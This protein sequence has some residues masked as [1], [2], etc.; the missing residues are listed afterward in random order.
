M[1][2]YILSVLSSFVATVASKPCNTKPTATID[3]GPIVGV[4]TE[5]PKGHSRVNKFLGIPFSGKQERFALPKS[6]PKWIKPLQADEF[7]ASCPQYYVVN[8]AHHP[9]I[10]SGSD[11]SLSRSCPR[12][13]DLGKLI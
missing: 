11:D 3:S 13:F 2:L 9:S 4:A 8:G 6:P 7:G 10:V 1:R 5:L 12:D